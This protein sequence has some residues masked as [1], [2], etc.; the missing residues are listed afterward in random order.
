MPGE[1]PL[2]LLE[3]FHRNLAFSSSPVKTLQPR[4]ARQSTPANQPLAAE[5]DRI[6]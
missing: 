2:I 3:S 4:S 6:A 1:S 5:M